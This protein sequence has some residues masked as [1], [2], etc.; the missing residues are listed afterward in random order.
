MSQDNTPEKDP[1]TLE[2]FV[3]DTVGIAELSPGGASATP[4]AEPIPEPEKTEEEIQAEREEV[5]RKVL[6]RK[7]ELADKYVAPHKKASRRVKAEDLPRVIED[8]KI[9]HEMCM[10]GRG[11]YNTAYALAHSQIDDQDPLRFFVS[12]KGEVYINPFIVS[13]NHVMKQI[14]EGCMT[15]PDEP[16]RTV[17]R[18]EKVTVKYRTIAHKVNPAT[19]ETLGEPYLTNEITSDFDGMMAQIMQHECQHLN[20]WDIYREGTGALK[21]IGEPVAHEA[22]DTIKT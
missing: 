11:E 21:A 3:A 8:A 22:I 12:I 17:T 16:M 7:V 4:A 9:M 1:N 20:G 18:F 5:I 19:G 15:Y 6:E 14:Q 13:S 2:V 10:V